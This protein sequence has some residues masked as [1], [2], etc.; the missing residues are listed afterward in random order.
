MLPVD[1]AGR[2]LSTVPQ[3]QPNNISQYLNHHISSPRSL[4][5][6]QELYIMYYKKNVLHKNARPCTK[7]FV[8]KCERV[9]A[10]FETVDVPGDGYCLL[11]S[12]TILT[13]TDF[14]DQYQPSL[15]GVLDLWAELQSPDKLSEVWAS[16]DVIHCRFIV[17]TYDGFKTGVGEIVGQKNDLLFVI[18]HWS[19]LPTYRS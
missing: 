2:L 19:L 6:P 18:K 15:E 11:T 4:S 13:G 8:E 5:C 12:I 1:V 14:V 17:L 10:N 3:S 16:T 9:F 7:A